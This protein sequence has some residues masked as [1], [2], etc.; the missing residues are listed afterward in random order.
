MIILPAIDLLD[1]KCVRL[2]KGDY[3]RS[4]QVASDPIKTA[5]RFWDEGATHLHIVDLNGAKDGGNPNF[6]II[7]RLAK[8]GLKTQT[9]GGV[10]NMARLKDC[11][12]AGID[13]AVIGSA[14]VDD[15]DFLLTALQ[16]Y[17]A[18]IIVGIDADNRHVKTK[19]WLKNSRIDYLDFAAEVAGYGAKT[20]VFTDISRDGTLQGVNT[21]QTEAL[22]RTVNIDI[23]ASGG[24]N[25]YRD[26]QTLQSIGTHGV[27]LGKSLYAGALDLKTVI[28]QTAG[29][30]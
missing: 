4:E 12:S 18:K 8:L 19:G 27:I 14:A 21:E 15:K 1:G 2:Y 3:A 29:G 10:R 22:I 5:K 30:N 28:R 26:I 16:T 24:V 25:S 7:E 20:I 9:G 17:G 6:S 23:I 13:K 11:F